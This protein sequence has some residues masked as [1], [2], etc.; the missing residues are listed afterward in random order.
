VIH[1]SRIVGSVRDGCA[2]LPQM[3]STGSFDQSIKRVVRVLG[4]THLFLK[5]IVCCSSSRM[6]VMFARGIVG[7]GVDGL[8]SPR[9]YGAFG[10]TVR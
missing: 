1:T 2:A 10:V 9:F 6:C 5:K 4:S 8:S 3:L 7:A